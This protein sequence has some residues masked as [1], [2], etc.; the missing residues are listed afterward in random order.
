MPVL[1][2]GCTPEQQLNRLHTSFLSFRE[3]VLERL[4]KLERLI[5]ETR[6]RSDPP[7]RCTAMMAPQASMLDLN[8]R[9]YYVT[10]TKVSSVDDKLQAILA[11][12]RMVSPVQIGL[13]L[14]K[15]LF[16]D[17]ELAVSTRTGRSRV[18]GQSSKTL[19]PAKVCL[20]DNLVQQKC[21][22][23]EVEFSAV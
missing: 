23:G 1:E 7:T 19:D 15:V 20:I 21:G 4:D 17:A 5:L 9:S 8:G 16:T 3:E 6:A 11:N 10:T 13:E 2:D 14:N 12:P 22:L 18:H